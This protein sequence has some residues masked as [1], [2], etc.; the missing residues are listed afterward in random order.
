MAATCTGYRR[1]FR[2]GAC[3][4][5]R[6]APRRAC[7]PTPGRSAASEVRAARR[8]TN[9]PHIELLRRSHLVWAQR[10]LRSHC[11]QPFVAAVAP[12][13][14]RHLDSTAVCLASTGASPTGL[15]TSAP[16][17]VGDTSPPMRLLDPCIYTRDGVCDVPSRCP[18][19][20]WEDCNTAGTQ[21]CIR[22][23][24]FDSRCVSSAM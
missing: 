9:K 8:R 5:T 3:G 21:P 16:T 13:R 22:L 23:P 20:D 6:P 10:T 7:S 17:N 2:L 4:S 19:G 15:P 11:L 1:F 12:H 24:A 18:V 14:F